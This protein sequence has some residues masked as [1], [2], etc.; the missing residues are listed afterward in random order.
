MIEC[1]RGF[2]NKNLVVEIANRLGIRIMSGI[3]DA[4][5]SLLRSITTGKLAKGIILVKRR[6]L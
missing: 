1:V 6:M 3:A 5:C 4:A 2:Q